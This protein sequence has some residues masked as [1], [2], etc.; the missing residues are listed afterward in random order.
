LCVFHTPKSQQ[1]CTHAHCRCRSISWASRCRDRQMAEGSKRGG[2]PQGPPKIFLTWFL[3]QRGARGM[4]QKDLGSVP[5]RAPRDTH[6]DEM[7][8]QAHF[9]LA[10]CSGRAHTP[11]LPPGNQSTL[12]DALKP[13][14]REDTARFASRGLAAVHLCCLSERDRWKGPRH[15]CCLP[16]HL[17][18]TFYPTTARDCRYAGSSKKPALMQA[19]GLQRDQR[20]TRT[21]MPSFLFL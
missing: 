20:Q 8:S 7:A 16:C 6:R 18:C 1:G 17:F 12:K 2:Q 21:S 10:L 9:L 19:T 15:N 3:S 5:T 14:P 4:G 11:L 13:I